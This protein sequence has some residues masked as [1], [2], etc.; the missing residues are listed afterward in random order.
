[1]A[2]VTMVMMA[3]SVPVVRVVMLVS[4]LVGV[5]HTLGNYRRRRA[6]SHA[7]PPYA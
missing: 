5:R 4:V 6:F 2:A 3:V 1:M 7:V